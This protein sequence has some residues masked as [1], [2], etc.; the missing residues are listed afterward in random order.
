MLHDSYIFTFLMA[1][2]LKSAIYLALQY[3]KTLVYVFN[4]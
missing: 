4:P 1:A 2:N 3:H